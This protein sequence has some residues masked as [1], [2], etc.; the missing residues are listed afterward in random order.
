MKRAHIII[1]AVCALAVLSFS[2]R[3]QDHASPASATNSSA[4]KVQ[5]MPHYS[6]GQVIR[7]QLS[8]TTITNTR[9]SGTIS[10]PQ[11]AS[12]LTVTWN[13][14][15]RMEVL[16]AGNGSAENPDGS[17]R[18]R[19][20]YEKSVAS[21]STDAYDPEAEGIENQYH[22]LEG[23][24][25][26]FLIDPSGRMTSVAGF[27]EASGEGASESAL[28]AWMGQMAATS[29]APREG[30]SIGQSWQSEQPVPS[31]PLAGLIWRSRSTYLRN[32]P[33][34]A[35]KSADVADA[36]AAPV[37][38]ASPA[39]AADLAA[40]EMCAVITTKVELIGSRGAGRDATPPGYR[41]NNLRTSGDWTGDGE[42][43][44]Y[45]SLQTGRL[46]SVAQSSSEKMNFTV[47]SL[48][49]GSNVHYDGEVKT[50]TQLSLA[51]DSPRHF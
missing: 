36:P 47:T 35:V 49:V 4:G 16:S 22:N 42:S 48:Q 30:I 5:L 3:A 33:C 51:P 29:G 28:R 21:H 12:A 24:S 23:K 27:D 2:T 39:P 34:S 31:S 7:Y 43:L 32:E 46:V 20:T 18:M 25:F 17:L 15:V 40:A 11:G 38:P 44:S 45:V 26:E 19:T 50:R 8:T 6:A 14:T 41:K 9:A 37:T 1:T 13:A 10:D